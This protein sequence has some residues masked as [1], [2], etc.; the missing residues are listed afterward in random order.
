MLRSTHILNGFFVLHWAKVFRFLIVGGLTFS[1]YYGV[2]W[3]AYGFFHMPY[4]GAV[5][6]SYSLAIVFHFLANKKITFNSITKKPQRQVVRYLAVAAL[7]YLVQLGVI[8]LCFESYE[9]NFY[10]ST[11]FG[12]LLTMIIGFVLMNFW[13]FVGEKS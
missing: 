5:A 13:V 7:N 11:F 2:L 3:V 12:V 1:I 10:M 9:V 8:R 6:V 4:P